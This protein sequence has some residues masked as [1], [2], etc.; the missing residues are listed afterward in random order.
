MVRADET[1]FVE[2]ESAIRGVAGESI[3]AVFQR[4]L[5]QR[6]KIAESQSASVRRYLI[7]LP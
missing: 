4:S 3:A 1:A 2:L 6:P 7:F 5:N